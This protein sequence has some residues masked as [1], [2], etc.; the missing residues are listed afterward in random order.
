MTT[1]KATILRLSPQ[2]LARLD[3]LAKRL[4]RTRAQLMR[5]AIDVL[6]ARYDRDTKVRRQARTRAIREADAAA[7]A[8]RGCEGG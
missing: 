2:Q 8:E 4:D 7:R 6:L 5:E 1:R 3:Q